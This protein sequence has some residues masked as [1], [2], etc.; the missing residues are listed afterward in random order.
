MRTLT[1]VVGIWTSS[2]MSAA[3]WAMLTKVIYSLDAIFLF[4]YCRSIFFNTMERNWHS[5]AGAAFLSMKRLSVVF[6]CRLQLQSS[7]SY[8]HPSLLATCT[9]GRELKLKRIRKNSIFF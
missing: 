3:P 1:I 7:T 6:T 2:L 9:S 4:K 5:Q 8:F